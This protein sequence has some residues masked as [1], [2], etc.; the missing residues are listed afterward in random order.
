MQLNYVLGLDLGIA[1]CGWAVLEVDERE[2]PMRLID[3]GVRSFDAAEN[4]KNGE[5]LAAYRRLKRAQRRL[6]QRRA[7][8]LS[9]LRRSL[10]RE[11]VLQ[12]A[13]FDERG[14]VRNLPNNVWTL[15][16]EGLDRRLQ[17]K[18]WA[19]VLLHLVKHRGYLSQRDMYYIA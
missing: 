10:Q 8:R 14:L 13:D 1:S 4:P 15:R 18:E 17:P 5:S 11:N 3:F 16:V 6:I 12:K 2:M 9:R 19:A 7:H